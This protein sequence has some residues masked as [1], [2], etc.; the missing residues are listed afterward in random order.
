MIPDTEL[1]NSWGV[2]RI[3]AGQVHASGNKGAGVKIGIIDSGIDYGHPEFSGRFAGGY[4]FV[5]NDEDPFDDYGHGTWVAGI[6]G[7]ADD[8]AGV[9]GV[10]PESSLYAYK[11]FDSSGNGSLDDIIAALDR[12]ILDG[13]DVVN[14]SFASVGD[15]GPD[16]LDACNR[17]LAAGIV[18]VAAAGNF[19]TFDLT[20]DNVGFPAVYESVIAV[21]GTTDTDSRA[22]G[23]STGPDVELAAPGF[24]IQ[25]TDKFGLY[26]FVDGTSMAA[27]H[28]AGTAALLIEAGWTN[29]RERLIATAYDLGDPGRDPVFGYG[30]VDAAAAVIPAPS[31]LGLALLGFLLVRTKCR[32]STPRKK[33]TH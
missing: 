29:V 16:L 30:L 4:D 23:S 21:S 27:P 11:V 2:N 17:A 22:L 12:A 20:A 26:T 28:V 6:I 1:I 10:A 25:T 14:M 7:A 19:G 8:G 3:G 13:I 33:P 32:P 24:Q 15:P 18:L 31:A 5:N 9:V